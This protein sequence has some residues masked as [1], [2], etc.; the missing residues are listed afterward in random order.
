V[1]ASVDS[2]TLR[3]TRGAFFTPPHLCDFVVEWAVRSSS[4]RV[5]EP[6]CGEAA[7]LTSAGRRLRTLGAP[8]PALQG[9]E[10]H[11]A[12]AIA[13]QARLAHEGLS[14]SIVV[15]DFFRVC[16]EGSV[17]VVV[18]NPPFVR[19]HDFAG[20]SAA[21]AREVAG[22]AGVQLTR[23]A[24]SWAAF[25]VHAATF[26]RPGGRLGLVVP[27]ELLS[28]N[29][30]ANVRRFLAQSF[31]SVRLVL[32]ANRAF[33]DV[34][35]DVVLLFADGYGCGPARKWEVQ[36][37]DDASALALSGPV[38]TDWAA[39]S[40][41]HRWSDVLLDSERREVFERTS[42]GPGVAPLQSWGETSLG[43]VTGNNRWFVRSPAEAGQLGLQSEELVPVSPPGS[44]HLRGLDF[45]ALDWRRMG[46]EGRRTELVRPGLEPGVSARRLIAEG[47]AAGVDRAYKCRVRKPWWRVPLVR[48]P[49]LFVTSMNADTPRLIGNSAQVRHLNSV[50]GLYLRPGL[51]EPGWDLPVAALNS[52]TV[53]GAEIVGRSYGGGILKLE[54]REA[55]LLPV[56][57][58][59]VVTGLS[60]ELRRVREQIARLL[61]G[62]HLLEAISLVDQ[63]V[64]VDGLGIAPSEV[65]CLEAGHRSLQARRVGRGRSAWKSG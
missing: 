59:E 46:V 41:G 4:E 33:P 5:L 40:D 50:H 23:L 17:D 54:P 18:G 38:S 31:E 63:I 1:L 6:S 11:A 45:T 12:S 26:L 58:P 15:D 47:V 49:D 30:A 42:S 19:F 21:R 35:Q 65:A 57:D 25:T 14:A 34:L 61:A 20:E 60:A 2:P 44:A 22:R 29:Y 36:R 64:L 55:D 27:A 10:I 8:V 56:P 9:V 16:G 3:K 7:F 53:L 51:R 32:F 37:I 52:L 48:P 62:R 43:M 39:A 28:V 24:S 13:A